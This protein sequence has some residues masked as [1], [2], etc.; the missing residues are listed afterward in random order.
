MDISKRTKVERKKKN[1][2]DEDINKISG[3]SVN[4]IDNSQEQNKNLKDLE[5]LS[6][7]VKNLQ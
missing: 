6:E 7:E 4:S 5:A 3:V 2:F 1:T